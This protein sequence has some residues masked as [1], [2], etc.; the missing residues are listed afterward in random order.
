MTSTSNSPTFESR[1]RAR[2]RASLPPA[3]HRG[4]DAGMGIGNV[5]D[6]IL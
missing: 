5:D 1:C 6:M 3:M 2:I 4:W